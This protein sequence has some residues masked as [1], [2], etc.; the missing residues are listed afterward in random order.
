MLAPQPSHRYQTADDVAADLTRYLEGGV[1]LAASESA[2]ASS[3]TQV[4]PAPTSRQFRPL[5]TVPTDPLPPEMMQAAAAAE[6]VRPAS[7]RRFPFTIRRP[8]Q[9]AL[10]GMAAFVVMMIILAQGAA[11]V[12]TERLRDRLGRI[13][14]TDIERL[15]TDIR[16]IQSNAPF[17]SA[18]NGRL[19]RAVT[20]RMLLIADRPIHDFRQDLFVSQLQWQEAQRSLALAAE[21]AGS[22]QRVA[23]RTALVDAHLTRIAARENSR[24]RQKRL[25]TAMSRFIEAARLDSS[26]P[27]PYLGQ[28]RINAYDLHDLD[29]LTASLA[30][31]EKRGYVLGRRERTQL[32]DTL[33]YRADR[34]FEQAVR[35]PFE[36]RRRLLAQAGADYEAC[37][38]KFDG[39]T[40]YHDAEKVLAYCQGRRAVAQR[41]VREMDEL[42]DSGAPDASSDR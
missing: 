24:D 16:R 25:S 29:A 23:A 42:S 22:D 27:D 1:P 21:F 38:M 2:R 28:A 20:E 14:A 15:R 6:P 7:P 40:N 13:E 17:P 39:L 11:W 30:E 36:D 8:A 41:M 34:T 33:R 35:A 9:T 18:L 26:S 4:I 19:R 10:R 32:G 3:A 12:R 37:V 31:A 5:D